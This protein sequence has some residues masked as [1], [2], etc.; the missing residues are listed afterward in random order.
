MTAPA[1]ILDQPP[2]LST[3]WLCA[4]YNDIIYRY[5]DICHDIVINMIS[6]AISCISSMISWTDICHDIVIYVYDIIGLNS[7]W[8]PW[9]V[10]KSMIYTGIS[11]SKQFLVPLKCPKFHD[12]PTDIMKIFM[13]SVGQK[14]LSWSSNEICWSSN[15]LS[16]DFR[17][18]SWGM[19]DLLS[20]CR[21]RSDMGRLS[22]TAAS[23]SEVLIQ[24]SP[25]PSS[26]RATCLVSAAVQAC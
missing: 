12:I 13:I 19:W 25:C 11:V 2:Y 26:T 6:L 7:S 9:N 3:W 1:T 15:K 10:S 22:L 24:P 8:Y 4:S 5:N 14:M 18:I 16:D 21:T 20:T 17:P 23:G